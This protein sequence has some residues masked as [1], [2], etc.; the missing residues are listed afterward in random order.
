MQKNPFIAEAFAITRRGGASLKVAR[1]LIEGAEK[2]ARDERARV[3]VTIR[4]LA[5][6]KAKEF[7]KKEGITDPYAALYEI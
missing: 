4:A 6:K 3:P 7:M 1:L 2:W 5:I